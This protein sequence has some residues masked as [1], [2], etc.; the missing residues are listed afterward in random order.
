MILGWQS[1]TTKQLNHRHCVDSCVEVPKTSFKLDN[2]W[3]KLTLN[4]ITSKQLVMS[5]LWANL[6]YLEATPVQPHSVQWFFF[7]LLACTVFSWVETWIY[8]RRRG[9]GA[10][11]SP[12]ADESAHWIVY[13]ADETLW[14]CTNRFFSGNTSDA[15][16]PTDCF[17]FL[18]DASLPRTSQRDGSRHFESSVADGCVPKKT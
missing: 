17:M 16:R 12:S 5:I 1:T 6:R 3:V 8:K 9:C 7:F 10:R 11:G 13:R 18:K 2:K 14:S 15:L 4:S